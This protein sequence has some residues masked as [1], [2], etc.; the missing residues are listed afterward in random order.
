MP[1]A[2]KKPKPWTMPIWMESYR[3]LIG[4]TGGNSVEELM[5]DNTDSRVNLP[6]A[7]LSVAVQSQVHLLERLYA[8]RMLSFATPPTLAR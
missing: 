2:A 4:N 5:N 7:I 8:R 6:L 1:A 3:D